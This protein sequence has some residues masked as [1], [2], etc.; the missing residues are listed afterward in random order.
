M[1]YIAKKRISYPVFIM[2]LV[3]S[4]FI[5][6]VGNSFSSEHIEESADMKLPSDT[7]ITGEMNE[8]SEISI[9]VDNTRYSL[10]SNVR[11]FSPRNR[12]ILFRDIEGAEEVK[13]FRN[14]DCV[15]K[16]NVLRFAQ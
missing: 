10:C 3:L 14:K 7:V 11:I 13:L 4:V 8:Y 16:I 6:T 15:R 9:V 2:I 1:I 12:V 5:I